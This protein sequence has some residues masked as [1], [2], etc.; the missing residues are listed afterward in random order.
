MSSTQPPNPIKIK[1]KRKINKDNH[2]KYFAK[3]CNKYGYKYSKYKASI[4]WEGPAIILPKENC[5]QIKD[6]MATIKIKLAMDFINRDMIAIYPCKKENVDSI[7]YTYIHELTINKID[8]I[9]WEFMGQSFLLN[10]ITGNVYHTDTEDFVGRK[11]HDNII[12]Y[13]IKE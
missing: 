12:D 8:C 11:T 2:Y 5:K 7:N 3:L 6:I 1:L 13:D 9:D 4:L 10:E